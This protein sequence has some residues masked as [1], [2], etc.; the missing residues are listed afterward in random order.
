MRLAAA[1][2]W[3]ARA[4]AVLAA[5]AA[6]AL[7]SIDVDSYR[8]EIAAEFRN[9]TGRD[10][11]IGGDIDLSISLTPAVTVE[12]LAIA[13]TGWGSQPSMVSL[14][15][16]EAEVELLPLL[17]GD[18]RVTRLI[19]VEP[20]ILL[21]VNAD[22]LSNWRAGPPPDDRSG[23]PAGSVGEA[24]RKD[25][26]GGGPPSVPIFN[27][28]EIRRG[29]LTYRDARTGEEMRFDLDRVSARA[30]SFDAPLEIDAGGAWNGAPFSISGTVKS[31]A[32]VASGGPARL[33]L[34]AEAFGF[35][36]R[37]AGTV[38][39]PGEPDGLDLSVAVRGAD[40]S[41]L[42]PLA[43]PGLSKLGPVAFDARLK[44]G[45]DK[46]R[47]E[48]LKAAL[49]ASDLSGR[50]DLVLSGPRPRVSGVL[51]SSGIDLAGLRP[52]PAG[53]S[54]PA[55]A[56]SGAKRQK[57]QPDRVFPDGPL[58]LDGLKA[59]DLD[60][61]LSVERLAGYSVPVGAVQ[62][63]IS[64]DNG[65]LSVEPFS[66]T[67][68]GSRVDGELRIDAHGAT[69]SFRLA[70]GAPELDL[71]RLLEETG[72]TGLF[73]GKAKASIDLASSGGSVAALMAGLDGDI[74]LVGGSGRLKTE[75]LDA[76]VGGAGA[77]LGTLFSGRKQW[78]VVNCAVVSIGIEKGR[79]TS[80]AALIDTEYSTVAAKGT[81]DLAS[82]TLDLIV[83]PRA[84]SATLNI[85][86]PVLVR[87]TF[88]NPEFRPETGAAL[89]KLGGLAAIALFPPAAVVGLGELGGGDNECLKVATAK[90]EAKAAAQTG[91]ASPETA[92]RELRDNLKG[93]VKNIGRSLKGLFGGKKD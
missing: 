88:A 1:L 59:V 80:R 45:A 33:E 83:E 39:E 63:G 24:E 64:L 3:A 41:T 65:M 19:L 71:G 6:A 27:R 84:K 75:A 7:Y 23:A 29:R 25:E 4:V 51:E 68:A 86:V 78:T 93:A 20:D 42:A 91:P 18:I 47:I 40:L 76:A 9:A 52:G 53:S 72:A 66:A 43:G 55:G 81:A 2:K 56:G 10:L 60:L 46:L 92:V 54:R 49:A 21:E 57:G 8:D 79:A 16:A 70:A 17:T 58:P 48:D 89:K 14:E 44:G 67:V 90:P 35:G 82:E 34:E 30:A 77:V 73:E 38:A 31:L 62:A 26:A 36:A 69:P 61:T 12:R 85:A 5:A 11:A 15:R 22:G 37:L 28:V 50:I 13:N 74:R 87:G 32:S